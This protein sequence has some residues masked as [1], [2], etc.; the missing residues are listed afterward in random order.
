MFALYLIAMDLDCT[1]LPQT[2][3]SMLNLPRFKVGIVYCAIFKNLPPP[4]RPPNDAER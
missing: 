2:I 4:K 1:R 3:Y